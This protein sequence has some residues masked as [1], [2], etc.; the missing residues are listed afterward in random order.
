MGC[1][2]GKHALGVLL[3]AWALLEAIPGAGAAPSSCEAPVSLA[4]S[5]T[6]RLDPEGKGEREGWFQGKLP[7]G[8][9]M[10]IPGTTDRAGLGP[11]EARFDQGH[12]VRAHK[13]VGPAWYERDVEIPEA[14]RGRFAEFIVE[15]AI[16]STRVWIDG[17]PVG[18]SEDSL[19][20]PHRHGLGALAPGRH[21][22]TVCVDNS[23][24][25][26]LGTLSHS[27]TEETQSIW[28]G[29]VGR[30]ELVA[31]PALAIERVRPFLT[32]DREGL[33][34]E[35]TL[36]NHTRTPIGGR[37]LGRLLDGQ[38]R[39]L[40][41][42]SAVMNADHGSATESFAISPVGGLPLWDEFDPQLCELEVTLEAEGAA[43]RRALACGF[44]DFTRD[45]ASL[46]VNGRPTFLRG[47][48]ECCV[49]PRTG[50]PPTDVAS[51]LRIFEI[52]RAYGFNHFRF[53]TWCPPEAAF[54][55][56]DRLGIY[57]NP[58]TPTWIDGFWP[59]EFTQPRMSVRPGP[60]GSDPAVVEF[61]RR[62]LRRMQDAYGHHPSFCMVTIGNELGNADWEI[63]AR[64][65]DEARAH[66]PRQ[67][68]AV[69]TARELTPSDECFITHASKA[70]ATRGLGKASTSWD[71]AAGL[72]G[73]DVPVVSHETGQR[74]V[75]PDWRT[76][77]RFDG[78]LKPR[79][80]EVFRDLMAA[81]GLMRWN[82]AFTAAS[83]AWALEQYR[84]E[85][86]AIRR[87]PG[88]DGYQ[89]LQLNDFTG[90]GEALVGLLDAFW[91]P[92]GEGTA[93]SWGGFQ[94]PTVPLSRIDKFTWVAGETFRAQA[95]VSHFGSGPLKRTEATWR[96][97]DASGSLLASG[98]WPPADVMPG[99]VKELGELN[100]LLPD[101]PEA[102][103]LDLVVS[104]GGA[105][106][107]WRFW[108]FPR[109]AAAPA[110]PRQILVADAWSL[111]VR[112]ALHEGRTVLLAP[113]ALRHAE[114]FPGR[115]HSVYWSASMF[116]QPEGTLGLWCDPRHPA[117]AGFPNDGHSDWQWR[118]VVEG[119]T[120]FVLDRAPPSLQPIVAQVPDFHFPR[121]LASL[122][123]ARVGRGR[124]LVCG[125]HLGDADAAGQALR[126]S[127]VRYAESP[128]FRPRVDL[129]EAYLERLLAP[130]PPTGSTP[131]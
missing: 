125:L 94:A 73:L 69:S 37:V 107:R 116:S 100:Y 112:R 42:G 38:G 109:P 84:H 96:I 29:L 63:G 101:A 91:E 36:T 21:R 124:L 120:V 33:R 59:Q 5:W 45:G 103:R 85:I 76:L 119:S 126:T 72:K 61:T 17:R 19:T 117:L 67:I 115:F 70:G 102:R 10:R 93:A 11:P 55:A 106:N 128:A 111:A 40:G 58:E 127:L 32:F 62:E 7:G 131:R 56:A 89:L 41:S 99:E 79:N 86:E 118:T 65:I 66:D 14:W 90:Q 57:L 98:H 92:K 83:E 75:F 82:R 39:L 1:P 27:Y 71:F 22:L 60:F 49:F 130:R 77:R 28:N 47:N 74:P 43:D 95:L 68:F 88:F 46:R 15:R 44:R 18:G 50:H 9:R 104:V 87:T 113:R 54:A 12:L 80:L 121:K 35:V 108:V 97:L 16:W 30:V 13:H 4:G 6:V 25:V 31:R 110:E 51:W 3:M 24:Q 53:H 20:T 105:Q 48:I 129:P 2:R 81:R 34:V 122:F 114:A 52:A 23:L 123:E 8:S 64:L 26:S 78:P